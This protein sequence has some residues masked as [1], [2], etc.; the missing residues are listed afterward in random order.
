M[1]QDIIIRILNYISIF[2]AL[3]IVLPFHEFAHAFAAVK[4]GDMTPKLYNRY[5]LNPFAHFDTFGLLCFILAGFGWAKPVP[6]N[7]N[8]FNNYKKGCFFVAIAGVTMNYIIAFLAYPLF[9]VVLNYVPEFAYFTTVLELS[10][11]YMF[12]MSLV[13]F[14]FNLIPVYPLDGF[15]VVDVFS[16]KR[17]GLYH[18]LRN[19]GIYVL[20]FLVLLSIIS[21]YTGVWQLNILGI[22]L[23][24]AKGIIQIPIT[25]FW[26]L[27]F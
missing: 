11:Y 19:Y 27:I 26:G 15:R 23:N 3:L 25:A 24:Y 9:L 10:L 6:V 7:P 8:N 17:S 22:A 13:F 12:N 21:D 2:I 5:T 14:V 20:Y 18:F 1:T 4:S 16:K